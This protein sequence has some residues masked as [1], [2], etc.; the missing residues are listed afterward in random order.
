M[1]SLLELSNFINEA[2]DK[3]CLND[4]K[5]ISYDMTPWNHQIKGRFWTAELWRSMRIS[6]LIMHPSIQYQMTITRFID[7][8]QLS[9]SLHKIYHYSRSS[10]IVIRQINNDSE[11]NENENNENEN[12]ENENNENDVTV[13]YSSGSDYDQVNASKFLEWLEYSEYLL[14]FNIEM[15]DYN[16]MTSDS[17][18]DII[19]ILIEN[20]T[21]TIK[22]NCDQSRNNQIDFITSH[23]LMMHAIL[24]EM[25]PEQYYNELVIML[26]KHLGINNLSKITADYYC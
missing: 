24:L 2:K 21:I 10:E 18:T 16:Q 13:F 4:G 11:N 14:S 7:N 1:C 20:N 15:G 9:K 17:Q 8:A 26:D 22:I 23:I 6:K 25:N 12:N 5:G 3:D 19:N